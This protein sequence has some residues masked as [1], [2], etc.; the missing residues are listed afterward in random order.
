[1]SKT[2]AVAARVLRQLRHDRRFLGLSIVAPL[3]VIYITKAA[4]NSFNVPFINVSNSSS[5]SAPSW[6]TS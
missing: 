3:L 2:I 6:F 1:M 4:L 5:R